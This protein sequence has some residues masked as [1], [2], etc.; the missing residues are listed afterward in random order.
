MPPDP[1]LVAGGLWKRLL[2]MP[3]ALWQHGN[4]FI[5]LLNW[6]QRTVGPAVSG[7]AAAFPAGGRRFR[8]RWCLGRI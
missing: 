8:A 6:Q 4:D 5:Y 7:L 1:R 2:T 3:A